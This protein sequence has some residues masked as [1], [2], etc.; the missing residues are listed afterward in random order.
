MCRSTARHPVGPTRVRPW[1]PRRRDHE[2]HRQRHRH[3]QRARRA[4]PGARR[5]HRTLITSP[6]ACARQPPNGHGPDP[7]GSS[8]RRGADSAV[9][10]VRLDHGSDGRLGRRWPRRQLTKGKPVDDTTPGAPVGAV[11]SST[12]TGC[13]GRHRS[14]GPP[15]TSPRPPWDRAPS[16]CRSHRHAGH[17]AGP[18]PA[19]ATVTRAGAGPGLASARLAT[20]APAVPGAWGTPGPGTT[21]RVADV[22][23]P[24]EDPHTGGVDPGG[25]CTDLPTTM[26]CV[27]RRSARTA[28]AWA[29]PPTR[30]PRT[31]GWTRGARSPDGAPPSPMTGPTCDGGRD[32]RTPPDWPA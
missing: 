28:P 19:C 17:R 24:D 14:P 25:A 10:T 11:S 27:D 15:T 6:P 9:H 32:R 16:P 13:A 23:V 8:F 22:T 30:T 31:R 1:P 26:G 7:H 18:S 4:A 2:H 21:Q 5:G 29:G 12:S 20:A 3:R